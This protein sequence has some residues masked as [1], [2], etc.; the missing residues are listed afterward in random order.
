MIDVSNIYNIKKEDRVFIDTNI[1]IFLFSPSSIIKSSNHQIQKYSAVFTKLVEN[2]CDLYVNSHVVSEFINR[3]LRDDFKSN[4]NISGDKDYKK[5]Y[6]GSPEYNKTIKIVL[7][8]LKKFMATTKHINDD[9]ESFDISKAYDATNE[10]DFNDLIIADTIN[11][12]NLKLLTDDNDFKISLGINI[13][14]Y[15]SK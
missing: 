3:C 11:K 1:L 15:L 10:S 9:F 6:R 13:D 7:K 12:N 8:Q 4:F 2:K 5:D 14:W